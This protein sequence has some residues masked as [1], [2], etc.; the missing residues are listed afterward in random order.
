MQFRLNREIKAYCPDFA[1]VRAILREQS[2]GFVEVKDQVDHYYRIPPADEDGGTRRLKLRVEKGKRTLIYYWDRHEAGARTSRY[3]LAEANDPRIGEMLETALGTR[4][5]VRKQRE[6]WRK[7]N[8]I[9]NLDR[10]EGVGQLL[11]VE[12]L[13]EDGCD[14]DA[15][16]KEYRRLFAPCLGSYI[17][18]SNEDLVSA[19]TPPP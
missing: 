4:A 3:Q 18:G 2:A 7:D 12:V 5:V 1:P 10:V 17:I 11:E 9:F 14:I 13:A 16:A 8:A 19:I 6:L 15:V